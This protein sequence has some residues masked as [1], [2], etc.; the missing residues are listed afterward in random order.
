[1]YVMHLAKSAAALADIVLPAAI[2]FEFNDIGHYGLGHGYLL[3]RPKVVDPPPECWPDIKILNE[4]G[5]SMTSAELWYADW[6]ELLQTVVAPAGLSYAQF[7]ERGYL[8]GDDQFKKYE[9]SGFKTKTGKV[10]LSL[11]QAAAFHLPA[12]PR[13]KELPEA[14]DPQ[15]PPVLT[16]AKSRYYLHSS[17]RWL[18]KLRAKRPHPQALIHPQT[19]AGNGPLIAYSPWSILYNEAGKRKVNS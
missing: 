18:E 10:E 16:S 8:K 15:Y 17:Y 11:S 9:L 5:K 14:A 2:Q 3:A 6:E 1:M 13:F 19:A 7:A 12:L 4:L